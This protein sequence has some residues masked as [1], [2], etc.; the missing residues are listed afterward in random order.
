VEPTAQLQFRDWSSLHA[1]LSWIYEGAVPDDYRHAHVSDRFLG[2]WLVQKGTLRLRQE[3]RVLTAQPGD[4]VVLKQ[5]EGDQEFSEDSR[6]L[7]VRFVAEWPDGQPFFDTGLSAVLKAADFPALEKTARRLLTAVQPL[8]PAVPTDLR[9]HGVSLRHFIEVKA[10]FWEWFSA[11]HDA[12]ASR[13]IHPTRTSIQDERIQTILHTLD[14]LPLAARVREEE[15][16]RQ[17][18][19]STAHFVRLFRSEV[20]TTPK[21]YFDDRRREACRRLLAFSEIPIKEIAISLGFL[22]LSDFSAWFKSS[23]R[24][25]PR[26]Y[27]ERERPKNPKSV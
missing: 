11:L 24:V 1:D 2:A 8:A 9:F 6:I 5:A 27:R 12:L 21:R 17:A 20:G 22:R 15:L 4:W 16:A 26:Q 10:R 13:D 23:H 18:R 7:S 3:G 14:Q 25:S 19:L